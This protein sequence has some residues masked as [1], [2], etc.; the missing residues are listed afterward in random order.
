MFRLVHPAARSCSSWLFEGLAEDDVWD[1]YRL[2][3]A[4]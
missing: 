1:G 2:P 4:K 3:T